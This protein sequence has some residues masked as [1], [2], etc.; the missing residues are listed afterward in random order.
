MS[1]WMACRFC[2]TP[3][4]RWFGMLENWDTG[5][6]AY[7]VAEAETAKTEEGVKVKVT[8]RNGISMNFEMDVAQSSDLIARIGRVLDAHRTQIPPMGGA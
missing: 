3:D 5:A 1:R 2:K 4:A 8:F 6:Q 7:T